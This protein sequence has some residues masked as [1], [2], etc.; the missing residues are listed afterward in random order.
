MNKKILVIGAGRSGRGMLGE[1]AFLDGDKIC[2]ADKDSGLVQGLRQQGWYTVQKTNLVKKTNEETKVTGFRILDTVKEHQAYIEEIAASEYVMTALMPDA[3]DRVI[4]D[5]TE[6]VRLKMERDNRAPLFVT[7]GANYVGLFETF[8]RGIRSRL[9]AEEEAFFDS[10]IY[11]VM[12][13]VNRKN[14]LPPEAAED[15]YRIIGDDKPV[16]RVENIPELAAA[17][18]RPAFLKLEDNLSAA[19]AIKIWSGNLVQC[20]MAFVALSKGIVDSYEAAYDADASRIAYYAADEGYRAVAAE[21]GLP[22][23]TEQEKQKPVAI[24]RNDRFSD[25]LHRIAREPLRKFGRNDRFIGPALCCMKHG[26]LPYHICQGLAYGFLYDNEKD[27][28]CRELGKSIETL[29]IERTIERYCGLDLQV[30]EERVIFDLIRNA[31][32]E[33]SGKNPMDE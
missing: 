10:C 17:L 23:R 6:A 29:G 13:I 12:S 16:L 7:L 3:F 32:Y 18:D 27:S 5:L 31:Y 33:C 2:F 14:L 1:M 15:T 24:F 8:D 9:K 30:K 28:Q 26:I 4:E 21:Y 19:M 25:S 22:A 20:S 11:L